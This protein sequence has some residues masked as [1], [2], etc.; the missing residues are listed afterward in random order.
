[1]KFPL[2]GVRM[3][4]VEQYRAGPFETMQQADLG[5]EII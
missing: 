4:S 1:M 5:A 3:I 2:D